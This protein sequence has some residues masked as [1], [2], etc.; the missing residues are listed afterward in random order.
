[1]HQDTTENLQM[2]I[3]EALILASKVEQKIKSYQQSLVYSGY[4][5]SI[6]KHFREDSLLHPLFTWETI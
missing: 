6:L 2:D 4:T 3:I 5:L 1:M